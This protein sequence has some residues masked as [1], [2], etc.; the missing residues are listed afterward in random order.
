MPGI[1]DSSIPRFPAGI[2]SYGQNFL[3]ANT[4]MQLNPQEQAFYA[5]HL[6]NLYGPGGVTH[7]DGSRSTLY[8]TSVGIGD[9]YYNLPTVYDGKILSPDDAIA[10]A[11]QQGLDNFPSYPTEEEA[12]ARYQQMHG[13]ME[14]DMRDWMTAGRPT[15]GLGILGSQP[16]QLQSQ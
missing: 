16:T 14:N 6:Q 1:L 3:A 10:R 9:K 2:N 5:R 7:P 4:A 13:Y 8:Q 15:M 12:E 11:R